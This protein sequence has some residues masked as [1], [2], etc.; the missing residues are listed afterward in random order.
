MNAYIRSLTADELRAKMESDGALILEIPKDFKYRL[1][2][3]ESISKISPRSFLEIMDLTR[4]EFGRFAKALR[5]KLEKMYRTE[6]ANMDEDIREK[7]SIGFVAYFMITQFIEDMTTSYEYQKRGGLIWEIMASGLEAG[8]AKFDLRMMA[9]EQT[10]ADDVET[11]KDKEVIRAT[12][13]EMC[14]YLRG[15]VSM[16]KEKLEKEMS[17]LYDQVIQGLCHTWMTD[18]EIERT[19]QAT[20]QAVEKFMQTYSEVSKRKEALDAFWAEDSTTP[21]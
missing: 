4:F 12:R 9:R 20:I 18:K 14:E 11:I 19:S 13:S 15:F 17:I 21:L 16:D 7:G 3:P 2:W 5:R 6:I 1:V 8:L 10:L